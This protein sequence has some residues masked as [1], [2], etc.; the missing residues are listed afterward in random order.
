MV[1]ILVNI[2]FLLM[3]LVR[4]MF[5]CGLFM[6]GV[7]ISVIWCCRVLVLVLLLMLM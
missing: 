5:G 1:L 2:S 6:L 7:L 4:V 3:M